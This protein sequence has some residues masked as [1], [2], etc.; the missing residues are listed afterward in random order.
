MLAA[1][2]AM[3]RPVSGAFNLLNAAASKIGAAL[4]RPAR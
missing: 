4:P 2:A 3:G 1:A